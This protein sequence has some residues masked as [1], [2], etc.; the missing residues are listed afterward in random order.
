MPA[1]CGQSISEI[2]LP[3][4]F[5]NGFVL[6]QSEHTSVSQSEF[7]FDQF[8]NPR[9][10]FKLILGSLDGVIICPESKKKMYS[11][12]GLRTNLGLVAYD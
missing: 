11:I 2:L 12:W 4:G 5:S 1:A 10:S 6:N 7:E 8:E 3:G 9:K